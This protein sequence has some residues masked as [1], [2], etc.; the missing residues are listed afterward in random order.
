MF[1]WAVIMSENG[2]ISQGEVVIYQ[3]D[4]GETKIDVKFIDETVQF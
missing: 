4:D 1:I 2:N 3:T